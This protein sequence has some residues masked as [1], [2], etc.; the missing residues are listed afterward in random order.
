MDYDPITPFG[1]SLRDAR[2]LAA[3]PQATQAPCPTVDKWQALR[4]LSTCRGDYALSDRDL[5][6]LQALI[7]FHPRTDL[8]LDG[9]GL[10]R[11]ALRWPTHATVA[12][13]VRGRGDIFPLFPSYALTA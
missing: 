11:P 2:S 6:V 5:A 1:R 4:A 10:T 12:D 3:T 8:A 13:V 7:S 9:V